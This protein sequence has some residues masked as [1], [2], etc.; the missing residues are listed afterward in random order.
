LP[1]LYTQVLSHYPLGA[2]QYYGYLVLYNLAY[3][4]DD[5]LMVA[6][7]LVTLGQRKLQ[8][9]EGRWLKLLSGGVIIALGAM[10]VFAPEMLA[11]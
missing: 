1:A 4:A 6:I 3:I 9:R 11:G 7:A 10:L 2:A 8:E 5:S